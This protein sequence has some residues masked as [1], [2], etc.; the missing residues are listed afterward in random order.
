MGK[1]AQFSVVFVFSH[2]LD[3]MDFLCTYVQYLDR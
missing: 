1:F 2:D 3:F